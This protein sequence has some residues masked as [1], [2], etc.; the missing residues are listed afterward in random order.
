MMD[1]QLNPTKQGLQYSDDIQYKYIIL[2]LM[3]LIQTDIP[4]YSTIETLLFKNISLSD[5]YLYTKYVFWFKI[6]VSAYLV[7]F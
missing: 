1:N 5:R 2:I 6:S 7:F 4:E 3:L